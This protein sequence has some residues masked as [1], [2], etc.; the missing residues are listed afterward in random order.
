MGPRTHNGSFWRTDHPQEISPEGFP[1][2]RIMPPAL[3]RRLTKTCVCVCVCVKFREETDPRTLCICGISGTEPGNVRPPQ[4]DLEL[5]I[6]SLF[7]GYGS[8]IPSFSP[9]PKT[10]IGPHFCVIFLEELG[11]EEGQQ[12]TKAVKTADS[13]PCLPSPPNL[14]L[15]LSQSQSRQMHCCCDGVGWEGGERGRKLRSLL[16]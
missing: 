16:A 15:C 2:H 9:V 4:P 3:A 8:C 13:H 6:F 1:K 7:P 14:S 5:Q 12:R 10:A 11:A